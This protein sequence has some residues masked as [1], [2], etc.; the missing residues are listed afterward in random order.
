MAIDIVQVQQQAVAIEGNAVVEIPKGKTIVDP[1]N[2]MA[3][4]EVVTKESAEFRI[5]GKETLWFC[6]LVEMD[7]SQGWVEFEV[8]SKHGG[9]DKKR[10]N[11]K[12]GR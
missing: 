11:V 4:Y 3:T 2:N 7:G 12:L 8:K 6:A 10:I 1:L 5:K 9:T